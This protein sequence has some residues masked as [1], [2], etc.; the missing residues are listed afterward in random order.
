MPLSSTEPT[1]VCETHVV[2]APL[3]KDRWWN[4]PFLCQVVDRT[5]DFKSLAVHRTKERAVHTLVSDYISL[6]AMANMRLTV[7]T[8]KCQLTIY[9]A[10]R[11]YLLNTI[12]R[13]VSNDKFGK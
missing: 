6:L 1:I 12:H 9:I 4:L 8:F 7:M 10:I 3:P 2:S 13:E 11:I 5:E